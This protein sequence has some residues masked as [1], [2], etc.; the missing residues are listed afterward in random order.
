M[1][2]TIFMEEEHDNADWGDPEPTPLAMYQQMS[3]FAH[4]AFVA[5]FEP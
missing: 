4:S 1:R 5:S 2:H 3:R